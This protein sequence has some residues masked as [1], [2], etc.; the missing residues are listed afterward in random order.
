MTGDGQ[1][2]CIGDREFHRHD[3]VAR[4][5]TSYVCSQY[6]VVKSSMFY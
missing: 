6:V 4:L 2:A 1:D 3:P 5:V